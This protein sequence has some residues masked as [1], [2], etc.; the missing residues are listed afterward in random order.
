MT[1]IVFPLPD[2]SSNTKFRY[3]YIAISYSNAIQIHCSFFIQIH[4]FC[5]NFSSSIS[6][7]VEF[8][9]SKCIIQGAHLKP[10][11]QL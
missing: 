2:F 1:N 7:W 4:S 9:L 8:F 11:I 10:V 5:F 3:K 6:Q